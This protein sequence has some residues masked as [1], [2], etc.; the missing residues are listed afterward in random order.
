MTLN[1]KNL[2]YIIAIFLAGAVT[3]CSKDYLDAP[4]KSS[5]DESVIFS[6]YDLAKSAVDG[7]KIDF[8]ETDSYRGRFLPWYGMN[9]DIEW[10]NSSEK[11]PDGK[12]DL[13]VYAA[14]PTNSQMNKTRNAWAKMYEGIERANMCIK[15]I[16]TYGDPQPGNDMG[17]LLGEALTL[18]A[19][20]YSDLLKAWGDV[21]ARF[22]PITTATLYLPKTSRDSIYKKLIADLGEAE[23]LVAW[24]NE[25]SATSDV[26]HV[27]KAF[28]KGFRARLCMVASGYSQYPDG[29][30]RSTDPD[31]SVDKMYTLALQECQDVINSGTV[32]LQ[33]SFETVFK[34]NCNDVI[35]AGNESL[36]EIPFAD[37]RGRMLFTFAVRHKSADQF[38]G[39]P[40]GGQAGP[41]PYMYYDYNGQ[42]TR[43]DVTCVPYYWGMADPNTGIA[44]QELSDIDTWYFGKY[45]Y[46][47]MTNR[48]V[49]STN[50]DGV[51]KIYMRY[52]E[53]ILM[54]AEAA[55]ELNGPSAAAPYLKMIRER[56]FP[57]SEWTDEVDN[58]I[59][60]LT[61]KDAMFNAIVKENKLEFTGEMIRKQS[62]IRWNLLDTKLNE[63][64]AKMYNLRAR[65]GEYADVPSEI[66]YDYADDGVTLKMYGLNRGETQDKS[67]DYAYHTS[68]ADP[69]NLVD[70]KVE[71]IY[72]QDP[73]QHQFWP[74]WQVFI[75]AS[76][77]K[78]TNDYGY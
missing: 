33:P 9:T 18:R 73:D 70:S 15:G 39:Q 48:R 34:N 16:K 72:A 67:G 14:T 54:A 11:Y 49:T 47:W 41:L 24:P 62:L 64:K 52:A 1:M 4:T 37:G 35:T 45:R 76:N 28:V 6:T 43:R 59:A 5:L 36:W 3:S 29:I 71:S 56:A 21:P 30:H 23:K 38:T 51:N 77:G 68:W 60:G 25:S 61:T 50:D 31:L 75:D 53:V 40:K 32:H 44:Q 58:Y 55:N 63:A 17:Q 10:Y 12:A 20:Y 7:I 57:Q 78:L 19:V 69:S 26:E 66:Y 8:G 13:C 42:D 74:I 2:I 27:S 22:E 65:T 46:E